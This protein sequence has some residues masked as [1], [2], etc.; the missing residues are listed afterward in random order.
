MRKALVVGV[1]HYEHIDALGGCV[2]DAHAV[3]SVMERNGDGTL[4]FDTRLMTGTGP[5]QQVSRADLRDAVEEL[6][7]DEADIALFYF[8]GHGYLEAAGGYLCAS[9]TRTGSDGLS[10]AEVMAFANTS[11]TRNKIVILDS[12]HSG[13]AGSH[14]VTQ[15]LSEIADGVTVL[16]AST[17]RQAALETEG[18]SGIFTD[19]LVDALN[20]AAANLVG[21]ITPGSVYAHIDQSLGSWGQR[22]VFKTNVKTFVSLRDVAPPISLSDLR[23]LTTVF[24]R[25]DHHL[26]LDPS[27]EP[28]RTDEQRNDP[29][30]PAPNPEHTATFALLQRYVRV[31]LVRPQ[32]EAHMWHA[33]MHNKSCA[34]TVLGQHYWNLV[35]EKRL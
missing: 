16:T 21:A 9:D 5:T 11:K 32:G 10:L 23:M 4:N 25:P 3:N 2:N 7:A 20:G 28:E 14:P 19:L 12:C 24:P 27:Y 34:L 29:S 13:I 35:D 31:N 15:Q 17:A 6:F 8:S 26:A 30:I 1:D 33:A 18:G 22:P